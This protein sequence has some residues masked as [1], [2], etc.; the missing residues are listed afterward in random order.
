MTVAELTA[1]WQALPGNTRGALWV[2]LA[3]CGF[4]AVSTLAKLLGAEL[5]SVQIAF[6]R[7]LAGFV[8]LLPLLLRAGPSVLRTTVPS[9]HV[10][11]A[12]AGSTAMLCGFYA[13]TALPLATATAIT[14][15]RPFFLIVL[16]VLFLGEAVRWRRWTATAVG[17]VGVL[18]MVRPGGGGLDPALLVALGQPAAVSVAILLL[19]RMP[20]D[21]RH[22]TVLGYMAA[23]S[24]LFLAIPAALVWRTPSAEQ[25][26]LVL[27]MGVV[28]VAAQAAVVR[29]FRA[30]EATAVAP[31]D[32]ARLLFATGIGV[33]FFAEVPDAWTAVG[34]AIIVVSTIY[35]A[36]REARLGTVKA[37]PTPV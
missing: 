25:L 9:L 37:G 3:T 31:F 21:E 36:R 24:T 4:S 19:K 22:L 27:L 11:R 30:G 34:A 12:V 33:A 13:I 8:V 16:A 28:G 6:F 23:L 5:H 35:I 15:A 29:G 32:Y 17:F 20:P 10:G 2:L 14:F 7:G 18:V 26:W 1:R